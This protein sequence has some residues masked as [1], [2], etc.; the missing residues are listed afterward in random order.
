MI[1]STMSNEDMGFGFPPFVFGLI[2]LIIGAVYF[3]PILYLYRFSSLIRKAL[4]NKDTQILDIAFRN[5]KAHY[6]YI[7]ILMIIALGI[8]VLM[9]AGMMI[10]GLLGHMF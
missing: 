4:Q 8:Y 9:F 3:F 10:G 5:L 1:F 6:K 7:G 2:Y